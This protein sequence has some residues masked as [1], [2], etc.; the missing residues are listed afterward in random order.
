M[1]NGSYEHSRHLYSLSSSKSKHKLT[2]KQLEHNRNLFKQEVVGFVNISLHDLGTD[3]PPLTPEDQPVVLVDLNGK[4]HQN[5]GQNCGEVESKPLKK[6][7]DEVLRNIQNEAALAQTPAIPA[8]NVLAQIEVPNK[9][10]EMDRFPEKPE[11]FREG[12][13]RW[14]D[15]VSSS[16]CFS[17]TAEAAVATIK[18]LEVAEATA[19]DKDSKEHTLSKESSAH[20][21]DKK[22]EMPLTESQSPR[23]NLPAAPTPIDTPAIPPPPAPQTP[24]APPLPSRKIETTTTIQQQALFYVSQTQAAELPQ[25]ASFPEAFVPQFQTLAAHQSSSSFHPSPQRQHPQHQQYEI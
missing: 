22:I 16:H 5:N 21:Q 20:D 15:A 3:S 17:Q 19:S 24:A 13:R 10:E 18:S 25:A 2:A 6:G 14:S 12:F 23:A 8:A 7:A 4:N 1:I 9:K 11:K